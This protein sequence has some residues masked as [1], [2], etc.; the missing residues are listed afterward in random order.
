MRLYTVAGRFDL[1]VSIG[2]IR[3]T[4]INVHLRGEGLHANYP[5]VATCPVL[6][7]AVASENSLTFFLLLK[8][9][10]PLLEEYVAPVALEALRLEQSFRLVGRI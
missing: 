2:L 7:A 9:R 4:R 5:L 1:R 8:G 6:M 3:G 10:I